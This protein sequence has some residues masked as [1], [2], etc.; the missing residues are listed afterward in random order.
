MNTLNT[1]DNF[2][3]AHNIHPSIS[4]ERL[5]FALFGAART[6]R[7]L[8]GSEAYNIALHQFNNTDISIR[9][10]KKATKMGLAEQQ[11]A[12]HALLLNLGVR[13]H[14]QTGLPLAGEELQSLRAS[15]KAEGERLIQDY[16][17]ER[18]ERV[19]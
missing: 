19:A 6:L 9:A 1:I 14:P 15:Y 13:V 18:Q 3:S 16:K 8:C 10:S 7:G 5:E 17:L 4:D 2:R 12:L 11:F